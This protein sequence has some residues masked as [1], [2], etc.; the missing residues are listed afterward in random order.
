MV[1][2]NFL[3]EAEAL[4]K[5]IENTEADCF[6]DLLKVAGIDVQEDLASQNLSAADFNRAD[7]TGANLSK[8]DL[9]AANLSRADLTGANLSNADL[10][11]ANLSRADLTGANLSNADLS[12]A[13]L[14]R[15]DLTGANLSNADLSAANL[16]G[17]NIEEADLSGT[18]FGNSNQLERNLRI[19]ARSLELLTSVYQMQLKDGKVEQPKKVST[20]PYK[21]NPKARARLK[22]TNRIIQRTID[23][24]IC[25]VEDLRSQEAEINRFIANIEKGEKGWRNIINTTKAA[26]STEPDAKLGQI[27]Q[28]KSELVSIRNDLGEGINNCLLEIDKLEKRKQGKHSSDKSNYDQIEIATLKGFANLSISYINAEGKSSELLSLEKETAMAGLSYPALTT[29]SE[30]TRK[31]LVSLKDEELSRFSVHRQE[32]NLIRQSL[33]T[34]SQKN[35]HKKHLKKLKMKNTND[36]E[37][38][39]QETMNILSSIREDN[40][41]CLNAAQTAFDR[42]MNSQGED[43]D[44]FLDAAIK[45]IRARR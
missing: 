19:W 34:K 17:A 28:Y 5:N 44:K 35:K 33:T 42:A 9:S 43:V 30:S 1:D 16:V 25:R 8:A 2:D 26:L 36:S 37:E 24:I 21:S 32:S 23:S 45:A 6:I 7:L 29:I 20:L 13:N 41:E 31:T 3:K 12:A 38:A 40:Q 27:R 15:A 11:A 22:A 14:S 39:F 4:I 10:S 18:N